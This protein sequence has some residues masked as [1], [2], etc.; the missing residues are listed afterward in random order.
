[1]GAYRGVFERAQA[2]T[3]TPPPQRTGKPAES[4]SLTGLLFAWS[5]Q[6][7]I[8]VN[9]PGTESLYLP[10]FSDEGN[11]RAMHEAAQVRFDRIKRIDNGAE[12]L[13]SIPSDITV[14]V[15]PYLTPEGRLRF[16]QVLQP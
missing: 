16:M 9:L 14:I 13:R 5:G 15:D 12:F 2:V 6:D 10:C 1:M 7:P 4:V 3:A 11:L 8:L